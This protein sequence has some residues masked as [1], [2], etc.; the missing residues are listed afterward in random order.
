VPLASAH[1]QCVPILSQVFDTTS[2][3]QTCGARETAAIQKSFVNLINLTFNRSVVA[4]L[5]SW[6]LSRLRLQCQCSRALHCI[7]TVRSSRSHCQA[8]RNMLCHRCGE[9]TRSPS[10]MLCGHTIA[11]D[12]CICMRPLAVTRMP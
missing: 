8:V 10:M 11:I 4:A 7:A 2:P 9:W 1:L 12:P 5:Q 3:S 6:N